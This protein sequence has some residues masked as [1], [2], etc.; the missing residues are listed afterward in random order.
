MSPDFRIASI[1]PPIQRVFDW[2]HISTIGIG[3]I[4]I[5]AMMVGFYRR[6]ST[7][8]LMTSNFLRTQGQP[9]CSQIG[10]AITGAK[11][12]NRIQVV[13]MK[14]APFPSTDSL[15]PLSPVKGMDGNSGMTFQV[16]LDT[17]Y[18]DRGACRS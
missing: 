12:I 2:I 9:C 3:L 11:M 7:Q 5:N 16:R 4:Q 1:G 17:E 6:Q 15:S 13:S 10:A 18:N 14:S 8:S